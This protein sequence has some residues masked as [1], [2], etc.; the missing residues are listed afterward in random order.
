VSEDPDCVRNLALDPA[1]RARCRELRRE[2]ETLLR[3]DRDPR[4]LGDGAIFDTY[5]Y[6][7]PRL[8]AFDAWERAHTAPGSSRPLPPSSGAGGDRG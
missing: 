4:V 6:L 3:E 5:R 1:G 2:M 8:H 7:G